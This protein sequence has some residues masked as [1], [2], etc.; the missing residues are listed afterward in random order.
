MYQSFK[1]KKTK[2]KRKIE[3]KRKKENIY[4]FL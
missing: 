4:S 2:E 1:L 3:V